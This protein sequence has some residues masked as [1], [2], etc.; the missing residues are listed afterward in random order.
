[1]IWWIKYIIWRTFIHITSGIFFADDALSFLS[2][3]LQLKA[4]Q[5][6]VKCFDKLQEA[7]ESCGVR[8]GASWNLL[9]C[10]STPKACFVQIFIQIIFWGK[11]Y[12]ILTARLLWVIT[13][14][15][16]RVWGRYCFPFF[17]CGMTDLR[18]LRSEDLVAYHDCDRSQ[19]VCSLDNT[20]MNQRLGLGEQL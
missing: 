3:P 1:M 12:W 15:N 19:Q 5:K 6:A 18:R 8:L 2:G 9:M 7:Q 10:N 11:C 17:L 13:C 4:C 14:D 16:L 20:V